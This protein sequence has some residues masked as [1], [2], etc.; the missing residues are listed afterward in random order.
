MNVLMVREHAVEAGPKR[1]GN[2][3]KISLVSLGRTMQ[4]HSVES[5]PVTTQ[6]H[7]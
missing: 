4:T 2:L 7:T 1:S 6:L 5:M 3:V